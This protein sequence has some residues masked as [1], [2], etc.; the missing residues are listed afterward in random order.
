MKSEIETSRSM[1]LSILEPAVIIINGRLYLAGCTSNFNTNNANECY[2]Y[3][4]MMKK[5]NK[6]FTLIELMAVIV[7]LGY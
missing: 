7:I 6:G 4:L 1:V 5:Y 3:I 2:S